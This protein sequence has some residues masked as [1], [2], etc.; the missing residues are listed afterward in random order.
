MRATF[1]LI[2]GFCQV[3]LNC[4]FRHQQGGDH[5]VHYS[6]HQI[7]S[8]LAAL[9]QRDISGAVPSFLFWHASGQHLHFVL[10]NLNLRC[11]TAV[12]SNVFIYW[13]ACD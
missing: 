2:A 6:V 5:E 10:A 9:H 1:A 12:L 4:S 3:F 11:Y 7:S 8:I 13:G